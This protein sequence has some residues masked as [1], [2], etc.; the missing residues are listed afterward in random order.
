MCV[1]CKRDGYLADPF[2]SNLTQRCQTHTVLRHDAS[3]FVPTGFLDESR[4]SGRRL[5][6]HALHSSC[7]S[8]QLFISRYKKIG[9]RGTKRH[10]PATPDEQICDQILK[11]HRRPMQSHS[12]CIIKCTNSHGLHRLSTTFSKCTVGKLQVARLQYIFVSVCES[13][14][15]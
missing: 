4:L 10:T 3:C 5:R 8:S 9:A 13:G 14:G 2:P 7:L 12:Q 1:C 15:H 11:K 6:L